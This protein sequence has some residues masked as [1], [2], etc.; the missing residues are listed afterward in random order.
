MCEG[1]TRLG[2]IGAAEPECAAVDVIAA[3]LGLSG[4]DARYRLA[5]F[6]VIVLQRDLGL[7]YGVQIWVHHNNA[8]DG[9]LVVSAVQFVG[10][11]A[12]V[13]PLN[14]NLLAALRIFRGGVTPP[15]LL[16][17][18]REQFEA[19]KVAVQNRQIFHVF[20]VEFDGYIG[21]VGL[22][23]RGF[24]GHFDLLTG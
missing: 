16:G 15:K 19:G 18:G 10:R 13:L 5:K 4:H 9:I 22:E 17:S 2:C 23:L 12:E 6:G 7:G 1:I 24:R 3:R 21:A 14:K 20:L 8:Q 11:S